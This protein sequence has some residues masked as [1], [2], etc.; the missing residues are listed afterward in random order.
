MTYAIQYRTSK[1]FRVETVKGIGVVKKLC[2]ML[3]NIISKLLLLKL[4]TI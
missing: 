1:S 4:Y 2:H 3:L